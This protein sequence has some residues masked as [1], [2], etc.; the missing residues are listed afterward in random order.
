MPRRPRGGPPPGERP[1]QPPPQEAAV[2]PVEKKKVDAAFWEKF[3]E[4]QTM[5]PETRFEAIKLFFA[6]Y[7]KSSSS[8]ESLK[9]QAFAFIFAHP[10]WC[11]AAAVQE[12]WGLER[13]RGVGHGTLGQAQEL[14]HIINRSKR[15]GK[16][17]RDLERKLRELKAPMS[18]GRKQIIAK[19]IAIL[20]NASQGI[21]P[22]DKDLAEEYPVQYGKGQVLFYLSQGTWQECIYG[23]QE[24]LDRIGMRDRIEQVKWLGSMDDEKMKQVLWELHDALEIG[25]EQDERVAEEKLAEEI[26]KWREGQGNKE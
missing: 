20:E 8:A 24:I 25:V 4:F 11:R 22:T 7:E 6:R 16:D 19:T 14:E 3:K 13:E 1:P 12:R 10:E 15:D 2:P 9:R 21:F 23:L 5:P 26:R 17:T 18:Q